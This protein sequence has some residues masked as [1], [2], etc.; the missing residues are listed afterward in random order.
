VNT[1]R[2]TNLDAPRFHL[3]LGTTSE[4]CDLRLRLQKTAKQLVVR[5]LRG[6]KATTESDLFDECAAALQF[7]D[8]F[9]ENWDALDE[10]L[11]DLD[12]LPGTGYVLIVVASE[13]LLAKE[14]KDRFELFLKM[15][16]RIAE[17]WSTPKKEGRT[18]SAKPF[19]IV[20]Q[21]DRADQHRFEARLH[22]LGISA[23][24]LK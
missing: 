3:L 5:L 18:R 20:F 12:W 16:D 6:S 4:A 2:L 14:P 7:P 9:G 21:V 19:H 13:H 8:Y 11:A 15:L 10:C 22:S 17:E 23:D 24:T 1:H